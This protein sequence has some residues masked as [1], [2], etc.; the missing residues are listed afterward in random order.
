MVA[1]RA[2]FLW[3]NDHIRNL[4]IL[5]QKVILPIILP[6]LEKNAGGHWN[7]A[8]QSLTLNVRKV[9]SD[10]DPSFFSECLAK[11]QEDIIK[12]KEMLERRESIW[13]YLE[14]SAVYK[15]MRSEAVPVSIFPSSVAIA[16]GTNSRAAIRS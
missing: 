4:V 12:E 9:F 8:V 7:Q 11:F 1:E 10:A 6:S 3:N 15:D 5:N 2:L 13:K 16:T 14:D